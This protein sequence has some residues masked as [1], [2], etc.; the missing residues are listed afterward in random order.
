MQLLFELYLIFW[1]IGSF[2]F[3]G[4]LAT[5]PLLQEFIVR[6]KG[7]LT[8]VE[9]N[10]VLTISNMTPGPIAINAAT[11]V[12]TKLGGI[13]GALL[14]TLGVITTQIILV[15]ILSYFLF[16]GRKVKLLDRILK[17]LKPGVVGLIAAVTVSVFI[18]SIFPETLISETGT[19]SLAAIHQGKLGAMMA[20]LPLKLNQANFWDLIAFAPFVLAML[21]LFKKKLDVYKLLLIGALFGI[22]VELIL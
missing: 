15:S 4:G 14:A 11:F 19:V 12:G 21:T 9:F 8:H 22:L 13:P 18:G 6:D 7:W 16:R 10:D 2:A 1:K 17:G 3:G 5:L 20:K